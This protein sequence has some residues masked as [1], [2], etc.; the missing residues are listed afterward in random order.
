MIGNVDG[1]PTAHL[2]GGG[3]V[4]TLTGRAAWA[5]RPARA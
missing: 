1:H 3:A 2:G 4:R 5:A